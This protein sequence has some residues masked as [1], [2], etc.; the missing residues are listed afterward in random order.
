MTSVFKSRHYK[1]IFNLQVIYRTFDE[2]EFA[3]FIAII[4]AD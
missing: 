4:L 3:R 2:A 1:F